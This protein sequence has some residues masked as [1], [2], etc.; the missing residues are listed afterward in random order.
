MNLQLKGQSDGRRKY[1]LKK[2]LAL[3]MIFSVLP[4]SPEKGGEGSG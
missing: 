4:I 3:R 1:S 2:I